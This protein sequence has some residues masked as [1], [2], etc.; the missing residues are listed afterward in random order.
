MERW[1]VSWGLPGTLCGYGE[2]GLNPCSLA[3][4]KDRLGLF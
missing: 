4:P 3:L 1:Q 2:G